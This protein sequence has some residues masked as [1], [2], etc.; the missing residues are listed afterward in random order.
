MTHII[1]SSITMNYT[2]HWIASLFC[3][4]LFAFLHFVVI[5]ILYC[6]CFR[7]IFYMLY[8]TVSNS[9]NKYIYSL[10]K[11]NHYLTFCMYIS[12]SYTCHFRKKIV[13]FCSWWKVGLDPCNFISYFENFTYL[14]SFWNMHLDITSVQGP[15]FIQPYL[16]GFCKFPWHKH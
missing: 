1:F 6:S 12:A 3:L 15:F 10:L 11:E 16:Q 14:Q 5:F 4:H 8:I 9:L 2:A 7:R 13:L